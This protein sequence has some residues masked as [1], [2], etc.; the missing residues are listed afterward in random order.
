MLTHLEH[1]EPRVTRERVGA[2]MERAAVRARR[3]VTV[4]EEG[5]QGRSIKVRILLPT[6]IGGTPAFPGTVVKITPWDLAL[7]GNKVEEI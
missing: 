3:A 4:V 6:M 7:L 2:A 1:R 5:D